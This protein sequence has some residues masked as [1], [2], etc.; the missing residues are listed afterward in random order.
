VLVT[1]APL[2]IQHWQIK[3]DAAAV[4]IV[5]DSGFESIWM[6]WRCQP[7]NWLLG[8]LSR[9]SW[10]GGAIRGWFLPGFTQRWWSRTQV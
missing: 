2:V 1:V 7:R 4:K 6:D 8:G 10:V 5:G 9:R 3:L